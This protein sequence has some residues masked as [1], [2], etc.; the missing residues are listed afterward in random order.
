VVDVDLDQLR[1]SYLRNAITNTG[2]REVSREDIAFLAEDCRA[3][4]EFVREQLA[5]LGVKLPDQG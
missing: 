3:S 4:R 5:E 2:V 1:R